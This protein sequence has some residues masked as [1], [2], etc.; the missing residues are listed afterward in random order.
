MDTIEIEFEV[1]SKVYASVIRRRLFRRERVVFDFVIVTGMLLVALLSRQT[2]AY[3]GTGLCLVLATA[4]YIRLSLA[5]GQWLAQSPHL[6]EKKRMWFTSDRISIET[7]L[8]KSEVRW[9][10]FPAWD[11]NPE[12]FMLDLNASGFCFLIPKTAFS[13]EQ[14]DQF[15]DWVSATLPKA[16]KRLKKG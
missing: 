14:Q 7:A 16:P 15:R 11:E 1:D 6:K 5:P 3:L 13:D 10:Y 12:F 9:T 4:H 8:V 2:A